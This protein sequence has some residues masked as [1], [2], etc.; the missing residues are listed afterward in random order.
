MLDHLDNIQ[1]NHIGTKDLFQAVWGQKSG[2]ISALR[3]QL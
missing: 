3:A 1:M 2:T